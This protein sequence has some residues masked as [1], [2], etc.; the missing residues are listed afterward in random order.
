MQLYNTAVIVSFPEALSLLL[1]HG[2]DPSIL[3]NSGRTVLHI[4]VIEGREE[5]KSK[6]RRVNNNHHSSAG[7]LECLEILLKKHVALNATEVCL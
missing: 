3:D 6:Q 2:A 4:A 7:Q 5:R 1:D